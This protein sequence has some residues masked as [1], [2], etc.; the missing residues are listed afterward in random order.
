VRAD[1]DELGAAADGIGGLLEALEREHEAAREAAVAALADERYFALL[2]RLDEVEPQLVGSSATL[3]SLWRDEFRRAKRAFAD[4]GPKSDDAEL[5]A[6]RIKVKRARYAAELAAPELGDDGEKFVKAAKQLQ[7]V[8]GEHQDAVV[9]RERIS[10]WAGDDPA[11]VAA[12]EPVLELQRERRK[13]ARSEWPA[14]W[15]SLR[16]RGR[17]VKA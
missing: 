8:L 14:A 5:H 4:L 6:A 9:A 13:K 12:A 10:E 16:R 15:K 17:K 1:L 2:D 11:R 3:G 7:D